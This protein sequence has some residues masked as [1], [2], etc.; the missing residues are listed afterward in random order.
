MARHIHLQPHLTTSELEA[1]FRHTRD[2]IE[3]GH[4][5]FLWL[6][7]RR[8]T[9]TTIACLAWNGSLTV[10][11][12]LVV[13]VIWYVV[14]FRQDRTDRPIMEQYADFRRAM[15]PPQGTGLIGD[16]DTLIAATAYVHQPNSQ[17][18]QS[19]HRWP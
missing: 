10:A 7:S 17:R 3:R 9:A 11:R 16:V 15:R 13:V 14:L 12:R 2:P 1:Y 18:L 19:R 6:L 5:Q 4:W 8:F